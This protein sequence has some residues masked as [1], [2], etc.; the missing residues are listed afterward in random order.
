MNAGFIGGAGENFES[1]AFKDQAKDPQVGCVLIDDKES[2]PEG[3]GEPAIVTMG[4]VLANAIDDACGARLLALPMTPERI[5]EAL[6][7]G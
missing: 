6:P 3:G 7:K 1:L 2:D 5:K 4:A